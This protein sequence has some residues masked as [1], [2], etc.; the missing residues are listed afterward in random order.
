MLIFN[1][2]NKIYADKKHFKNL[3]FNQY[4]LHI[5]QKCFFICNNHVILCYLHWIKF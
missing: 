2:H 5:G 3:L 4:S 1:I